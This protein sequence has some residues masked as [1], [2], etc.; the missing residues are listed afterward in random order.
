MKPMSVRRPSVLIPSIAAALLL[1]STACGAEPTPELPGGDTP[2]VLAPVVW[3]GEVA[4]DVDPDPDV[5]EV[6]L[7]SEEKEIDLG[8]GTVLP[9]LTYN[10]LYPGPRIEAKVGDEVVV[11]FV[12]GLREPQTIHWH[13]LRISD[14][15]DGSPRIQSPV[16]PGDS[17]EYRFVVPEAG[18]F[19]YHPHVRSNVAVERGLQGALVVHDP[20]DPH[21]DLE[22]VIVVDD[23]LLNADG[24]L[25]SFFG[26]HME[27]MHGRWGN[28]LLTNGRFSELATGEAVVGQAERWRIVNTANARTMSLSVEG[29]D[30]WVVGTDGGR[31]PTPYRSSRITVAVGQRYDLEVHYDAV[32]EVRLYNHVLSSDAQGN[33][34]ELALPNLVVDV[35]DTARAPT[36]I[37]WAPKDA[38]PER[39]V[40]RSEELVFDAV[41]GANGLEW[42]IN[43]VSHGMEP[44]F[45]FAEGETVELLLRNTLGPEHPFHLHGQFFAIAG[46]AQPGLKDTVL[47]PGMSD[48]RITAF[49]DN[50][51]RWMAHC[52]I[53]EHAELG[54]M[55]E[56]VVTPAP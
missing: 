43:G 37:V 38:L 3:G 1:G 50:P 39:S 56:I 16:E 31:L 36:E 23:L 48:V 33:T 9:M 5:V 24:T 52:H 11:H 28:V 7:T 21:F 22:R 13:G 41:Q 10:G 17:F 53:L 25:A 15:M 54:M 19:W 30:F 2:E 42:R 12:N 44:L 49:M 51:G 6:W 55:S 27:G 14:Q 46:T 29:A 40:D 8:G 47:V 45:T 18:T 26:S 4:K 20:A 35:V 32:G 34:V